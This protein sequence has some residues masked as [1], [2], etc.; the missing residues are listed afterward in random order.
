MRNISSL[1]TILVLSCS[2]LTAVGCATSGDD[3]YSDVESNASAPG[4]LDL[5]TSTDGQWRFHVVSGNGRTLMTSEGYTSRTGALNGVLSVLENGSDPAHYQVHATAVG[6]NLR[7]RA[8]NDEMIA[9][10][11]S[12]SSKS[13]A[14]R[15]IGACVRA[16]SSYIDDF[17]ANTGARVELSV[18][19]IGQYHFDVFDDNGELALSSEAYKTPESAWNGA[20]ASQDAA[21]RDAAFA[22]V[23]VGDGSYY[24]K[25]TAGNGELLGVSPPYASDAAAQDG[26]ASMRTLLASMKMI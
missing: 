6:Y 24:V 15:A 20:F 1:I 2:A 17:L 4:R 19:V 16:V 13:N 23:A 8:A 7:L 26:I 5:W 14:N 25:L 10:T 11:E 18:D 12:Y 22:V 21:A 3:E 9:S